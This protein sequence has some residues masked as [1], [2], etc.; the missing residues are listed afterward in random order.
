MMW[1]I[2]IV[3]ASLFILGKISKQQEIN[4]PEEINKFA[5]KLGNEIFA[6]EEGFKELSIEEQVE[7]FNK[8]WY[9]NNF[10]NRVCNMYGT[11]ANAIY[12]KFLEYVREGR[13]KQNK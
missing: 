5:L 1:I 3:I 13:F 10:G 12:N 4:R 11:K 8:T 9:Q 7:F 6:N 2:S